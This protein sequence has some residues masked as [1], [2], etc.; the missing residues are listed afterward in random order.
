MLQTENF[1]C[2][3]ST[4]LFS[5]SLLFIK[6]REI[7]KIEGIMLLLSIIFIMNINILKTNENSSKLFRAMCHLCGTTGMTEY[8]LYVR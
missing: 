2:L 8:R 4:Y 1:W 6:D 3:F 7:K 5:K